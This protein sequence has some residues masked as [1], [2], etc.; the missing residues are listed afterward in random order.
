M[1][2]TKQGYCVIWT[3]CM[4]GRAVSGIASAFI[5][6][7]KKVGHAIC[8]S[9]SC[10]PQN[11]SSHIS[12]A[13]LEFLYTQE[14][15]DE[16]NMKCSLAGHSCVQEVDN[17]HQQIEVAMRVAE[18]YPSISFLRVL[19]KVNRIWTYHVIQMKKNDF[20]DYNSSSRMLPFF[21]VPY[22]KIFQ[23]RFT[24]HNLHIAEYKI[25]HGQADLQQAFIG[26][27]LCNRRSINGKHAIQAMES[28]PKSE[29]KIVSSR[30][31]KSEKKLAKNKTDDLR[32]MLKLMPSVDKD[33]YTSVGITEH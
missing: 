23:L 31:Q 1:T 7:L 24:K 18:F 8:W 4:S 27:K 3:E 2:S 14:Q 17:M 6:I 33:Y 19:L 16:I 29:V 9:D 12:Q 13:I 32:S 30:K 26:K 22:T 10:D 28:K 21:K 20:K 25:Y 5:Q 15:I 11:R